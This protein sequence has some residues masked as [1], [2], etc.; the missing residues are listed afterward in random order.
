MTWITLGTVQM[1]K[2]SEF[3]WQSPPS[4]GNGDLIKI[5]WVTTTEVFP[6]IQSRIL[7][8]RRWGTDTEPAVLLYPSIE[9]QIIVK[10]T[11]PFTTVGLN[12]FTVEIKRYFRYRR[13]IISEPIYS[14][15]IENQ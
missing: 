8:R 5:T 3:I 10:P 1:A 11:L 6:Y 7:L 14:L 2:D 15:Q 9:P 4:F 13:Q 12:D